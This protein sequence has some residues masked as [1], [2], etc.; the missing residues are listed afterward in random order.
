MTTHYVTIGL[1]HIGPD[2]QVLKKDSP[3]KRQLRFDTEQRVIPDA[4]VPNSA[5]YPTIQQ[6]LT[7][8]AAASFQ[9]VQIGQT[10]IV[11]V[12]LT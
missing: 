1:V 10:F 11:T 2:G 5:N 8:E 3:I 7:A 4:N 12:K 6:Y 9:P